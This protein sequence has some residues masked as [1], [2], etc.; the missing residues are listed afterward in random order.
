VREVKRDRMILSDA[1]ILTYLAC[2]DVDPEV[3]VMAICARVLGGMRTGDL[4]AWTAEL[5]LEASRRSSSPDRRRGMS[6]RPNADD[7]EEMRVVVAGVGAA[8][9]PEWAGLP[10]RRGA[11]VG[12][13]KVDGNAYAGRL[14]RDSYGPA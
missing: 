14:R 7:P 1:E 9:L 8:R 6:A 12:A 10:V 13:F 2:A 4:N 3:R 5:D 11:R